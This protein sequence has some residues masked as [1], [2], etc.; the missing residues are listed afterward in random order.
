MALLTI[1]RKERLA[2]LDHIGRRL[3]RALFVLAAVWNRPT[4]VLRR[5]GDAEREN[6]NGEQGHFPHGRIIVPPWSLKSR[7]STVRA[8]GFCARLRSLAEA[9]A[10]CNQQRLTCPIT[11]AHPSQ[12]TETDRVL[13]SRA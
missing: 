2:F 5:A 3:Q 12:L 7:E 13:D 8:G 11:W 6:E 1:R 9:S 10:A 4:R